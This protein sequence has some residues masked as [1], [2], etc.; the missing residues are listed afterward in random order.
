MWRRRVLAKYRVEAGRKQRYLEMFRDIPVPEKLK[1][2]N[3]DWA[4]TN[5]AREDRILWYLRFVRASDLA[6]LAQVTDE[7]LAQLVQHLGPESTEAIKAAQP[8]IRRRLE[9]IIRAPAG[10][11]RYTERLNL[12]VEGGKR[13]GEIRSNLAHFIQN[14]K[15][16]GYRSVLEFE[17]PAHATPDKIFTTLHALEASEQAKRPDD[18]LI[19]RNDDEQEFLKVQGWVWFLI[20]RESC[21]REGR[22][23]RHCGNSNPHAGDQILSLREPVE[24][25]RGRKTEKLWKPHATFILNR[26]RL[27][28]MKGYGNTKP[29]PELHPY[30][31]ALLEDPR[32]EHVVGGG[33]KPQANF[34]LQDL[35][36]GQLRNLLQ[37]KPYLDHEDEHQE[38]EDD[39]GEDEEE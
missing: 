31:V 25:K 37:K 16:H 9:K 39:Y 30:I 4:L 13:L 2:D 28:E 17:F 19:G 26:G 20:D 5:L 10:S 27:G 38:P 36:Q 34:S 18:R 14:A 32:V 33:Y 24:V 8:A 3:I 11:P 7:Q 23:M 6:E 15:L 12:I 21:E 35:T 22:A 29:K 1:R